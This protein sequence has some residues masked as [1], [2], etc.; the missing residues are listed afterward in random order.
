MI[1]IRLCKQGNMQTYACRAF[2]I[3]TCLSGKS[4]FT[5]NTVKRDRCKECLDPLVEL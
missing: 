1:K 5:W 2:A 3:T 4:Q